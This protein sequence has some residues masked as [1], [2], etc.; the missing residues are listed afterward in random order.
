MLRV[1]GVPI[2]LH[3]LEEWIV[4]TSVTVRGAG[5]GPIDR[6][7]RVKKANLELTSG[8][9]VPPIVLCFVLVLNTDRLIF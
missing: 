1:T 8:L 3:D 2:I 6:E 4:I 5:E 9:S 7:G